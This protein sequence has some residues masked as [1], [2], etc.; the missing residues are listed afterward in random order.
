MKPKKVSRVIIACAVLYNLSLL[1]NEPDEGDQTT[2]D[3]DQPQPDTYQG[4]NDGRGIRDYIT[5]HFFN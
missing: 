2:D 5:N 4:Q 1:W 3:D